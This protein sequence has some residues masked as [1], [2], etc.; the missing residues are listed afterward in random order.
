VEGK[1]HR[2]TDYMCPV[3]SGIRSKQVL[4]WISAKPEG[5]GK[6]MNLYAVI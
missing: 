4:G 5:S 2:T 1:V 6:G 3:L